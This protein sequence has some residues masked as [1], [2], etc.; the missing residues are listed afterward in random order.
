MAYVLIVKIFFWHND[1]GYQVVAYN[2]CIPIVASWA[3]GLG[4]DD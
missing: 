1:N 4:C 3:H 2:C